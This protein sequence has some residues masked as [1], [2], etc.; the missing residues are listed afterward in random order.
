MRIAFRRIGFLGWRW[1]WCAIVHRPFYLQDN[2]NKWYCDICVKTE[3]E[4][5]RKKSWEEQE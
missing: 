1:L 3:L 5:L 4:K 2:E